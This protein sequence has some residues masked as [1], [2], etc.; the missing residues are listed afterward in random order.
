MSGEAHDAENLFDKFTR[1]DC[2]LTRMTIKLWT[3]WL[4]R[5]ILDGTLSPILYKSSERALASNRILM[6]EASAGAQGQS[7][8]HAAH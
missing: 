6:P 1:G 4:K 5:S 3:K 7:N 8:H 2:S